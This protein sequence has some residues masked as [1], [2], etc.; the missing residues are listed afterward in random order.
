MLGSDSRR[1]SFFTTRSSIGTVNSTCCTTNCVWSITV[2]SSIDTGEHRCDDDFG[3]RDYITLTLEITEDTSWSF[4]MTPVIVVGSNRSSWRTCWGLDLI[5]S[6]HNAGEIGGLYVTIRN[7]E[8]KVRISFEFVV[9]E[10]T[11]GDKEVCA[12]VIRA[13]TVEL[14]DHEDTTSIV[15]DMILGSSK[16]PST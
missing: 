16:G 7:T 5:I 9:G 10:I 2:S 12:I 14:S 4:P 13:W 15:M 3:F 8:S 1:S 11:I 6:F